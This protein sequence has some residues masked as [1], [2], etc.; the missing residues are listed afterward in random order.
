MRNTWTPLHLAAMANENPAVIETLLK[1]GAVL[2]ARDK[3]KNTPLHYA[4]RYNENPAV[5]ETLLKAGADGPCCEM[6]APP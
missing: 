1:A 5:I 6:D 2:E 4:A 3:W